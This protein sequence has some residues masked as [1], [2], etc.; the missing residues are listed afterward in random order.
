[1]V[2][3][4]N[5]GML[6]SLYQY[7]DIAM[8]GGAFRKGLHN[9]LEAAV[10]G[11]PVIYGIPINKYPEGKRLAKAGGGFMVNTTELLNTTLQ[12]L[13]NDGTKRLE[14][15]E[16]AKQFILSNAGAAEKIY[17]AIV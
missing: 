10:F 6:S 4:D 12:M 3:I 1:M 9:I 2:I 14:A 5:I 17:E 7:G 13:L 15:G 11:I 16:K 8:I